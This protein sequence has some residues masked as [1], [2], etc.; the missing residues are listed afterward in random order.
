MRALIGAIAMILVIQVAQ[1]DEVTTD[2]DRLLGR[3]DARSAQE[4]ESYSGD[5]AV[6]R[7]VGK[8]KKGKKGRKHASKSSKNRA[9]RDIAQS[10]AKKKHKHS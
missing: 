10:K 8:V 1:A 5:R 6:A 9:K 3:L 2:L 7:V 4:L